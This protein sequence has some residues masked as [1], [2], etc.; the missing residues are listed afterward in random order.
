MAEKRGSDELLPEVQF[1]NS[2]RRKRAAIPLSPIVGVIIIVILCGLS[3]GGGVAYEKSRPKSAAG[4]VAAGFGSGGSGP[5]RG[6]ASIGQ[7][8]AVSASS[9]TVNDQRSGSSKTYT[10]SSSTTITDNGQAAAAG[11]IATGDTVLVIAD[12]NNSTAAARIMVNPSFGGS[13]GQGPSES[14]PVQ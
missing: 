11:S 14:Q 10:I 12:G 1:L 5:M 9:I 8:T 2:T 13:A 4:P 3:F 7:V 6:N